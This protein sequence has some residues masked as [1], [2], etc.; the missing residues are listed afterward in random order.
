MISK[1]AGAFASLALCACA[2]NTPTPA[3]GPVID[4]GSEEAFDH[5]LRRMY[6]GLE[7]QHRSRLAVAVYILGLQRLESIGALDEQGRPK[8]KVRHYDIAE[9]IAGKRFEEIVALAKL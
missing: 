7:E 1:F 5:S 9:R 4:A 3:A 6:E 2:A 8:A